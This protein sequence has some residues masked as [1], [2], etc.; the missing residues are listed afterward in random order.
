MTP[1][2]PPRKEEA[3][4]APGYARLVFY[5]YFRKANLKGWFRFLLGWWLAFAVVGFFLAWNE[6]MAWFLGCLLFWLIVSY[7]A[8]MVFMIW[9]FDRATRDAL[10]EQEEEGGEL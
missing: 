6:H 3:Y 10:L 7:C 1:L 9:S 8:L 2:L 5:E 4:I